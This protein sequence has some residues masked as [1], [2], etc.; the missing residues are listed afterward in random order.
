MSSPAMLQGYPRVP[1]QPGWIGAL[2]S[3]DFDQRVGERNAAAPF[4]ERVVGQRVGDHRVRVMLVSPTP[5]NRD[6]T[7]THAVGDLG[8]YFDRGPVVEDA[9]VLAF[10]DASL[11]SVVG[12]DLEEGARLPAAV[13]GQV[14]VRAVEEA[15]VVLGRHQLQ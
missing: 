8:G 10:D 14:R 13:T 3:A 4:G 12:A 2:T 5:R 6:Q 1:A 15:V 7:R 9:R 11:G